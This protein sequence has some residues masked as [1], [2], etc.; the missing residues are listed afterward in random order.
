MKLT[1]KL[2]WRFQA[3]WSVAGGSLAF[4]SAG[5]TSGDVAEGIRK[6]FQDFEAYLASD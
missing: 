2:S 3:S 6:D 4:F 1:T 5:N